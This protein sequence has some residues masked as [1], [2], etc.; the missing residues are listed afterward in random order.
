MRITKKQF[1]VYPTMMVLAM[2]STVLGLMVPEIQ[3][4]FSFTLAEVGVLSTLQSVGML[5]SLVLCFSVFSAFNAIKVSAIAVVVFSGLM[6]WLG[7]N[8]NVVLLYFLFFLIGFFLNTIDALSNTVISLTAKT[9]INFYLGLLHALWALAGVGGP[10]LA[11]A[12][13]GNYTPAF[14]WLGI[15]MAA[16][17]VLYVFGLRA[18]IKMPMV[19]NKHNFGG[20]KKLAK[21]IRKKGMFTLVAINFFSCL[22]MN[23]Y[24]FFI[25]K[26]VEQSPDDKLSGAIMLSSM[27]LGLLI[28][29]LIFSKFVERIPI[30]KTMAITNALAIVA[31]GLMLVTTNPALMAVFA[32]VGS[33]LIGANFPALVIES[34]KIVPHDVSAA[35]SLIYFG[36]VMA[37]F[38]GPAAIGAIGDATGLQIALLINA[39][40]L[41]PVVV[42]A[43]KSS[44]QFD[45]PNG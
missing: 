8:T 35:S 28:G 15:I 39:A 43:A 37:L 38:V 3:A 23:T 25:S 27:F 33:L 42:L 13:G 36:L 20:L 5:V 32:G 6:I 4:A 14:L 16:A 21:L 11:I 9:H 24:I 41:V 40:M 18:Q 29:R 30:L 44:K 34:H 45:S 19:H 26:Y 12:L 17:A 22:T 31:F 10:F 1:F 2:Y 7:Y